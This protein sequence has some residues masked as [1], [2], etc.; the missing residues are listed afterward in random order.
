MRGHS[1]VGKIVEAIH[2]KV[3]DATHWLCS[4]IC[5]SSVNAAKTDFALQSE[6]SNDCCTYLTVTAISYSTLRRGLQ[7]SRTI[8]F[9]NLLL[10]GVTV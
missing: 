2:L 4:F 3:S 6:R 1:V 10:Y 8:L 5:V 7:S 9:I